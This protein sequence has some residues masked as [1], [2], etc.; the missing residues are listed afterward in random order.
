MSRWRQLVLELFPEH[1][2]WIE[3]GRETFSIYQLFFNLLPLAQEAH[4][5]QDRNTLAKMYKFA[6]WCWE[7]KRTSRFIHNAVGVAFYEHLVDK[8]SSLKEIQDWIKPEIFDDVKVLFKER[9]SPEAYQELLKRY[10][11]KHK[12]TFN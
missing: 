3:D 4:V 2:N 1:K 6:E 10:N 12:T 9:L 8:D 5:K 7:Q 11:S